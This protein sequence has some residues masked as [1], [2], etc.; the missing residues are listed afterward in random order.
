MTAEPTPAPSPSVTATPT[1]SVGSTYPYY[2]DDDVFDEADADQIVAQLDSG[3]GHIGAMSGAGLLASLVLLALQAER[4]RQ[5][6]HRRPGQR[7]PNP[8]HGH[9]ERELRVAEAPADVERLDLALRHLAAALVDHPRQ[10]DI[11]GVRVIGGDVQ[12]LLGAD[13]EAPPEPWL[14]EGSHWVLPGYVP[15]VDLPGSDARCPASPRSDPTKGD[16]VRFRALFADFA[17]PV[18]SIL[19]EL[20]GF[21]AIH[22]AQIEEMTLDSW[23]RGRVLLLGDAAHATSPNMAEGASMA[24]E[25]AL[26]L[27]QRC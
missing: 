24:L 21:N 9:T 26:V 16:L 27:A 25:D 4:R 10:P 18:P 17:E 2:T 5:T 14:D 1:P 23:A 11:V 15:L 3:S 7:L 8:R 22:F 20:D 12:L 6:Q 19:D 13:C